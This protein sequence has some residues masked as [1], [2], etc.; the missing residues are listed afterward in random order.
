MFLALREM[1]RAV[2]RYTLLVFAIGLLVFLILFQQALQDGLITSF[3]GGVRNQTAPVL[4][5]S[6]DAQRTLQGSAISPPL[7]E[8]I[9][10]ADGIEGSAR[11]G[12]STFTVR[13]DGDDETDAAILGTDDAEIFRPTSLS[14]GR[15]PRAAGEAVGSDADFSI[16]DEVEVVPTPPGSP[17]KVTVV[18]VAADIQLSV[19]PTLFTDLETYQGAVRAVNPEATDVLP[20]ALALVPSGGTSDATLVDAVNE[21]A[22]DA[23][24]LTRADAA[25][26]SPGVA[27]VRQSFQI[28][29][30]LYGLVVPLVT[31][32]FFL[33]ITLQKS[34]SL[35]LLRAMGARG[36]TLVRS[37]LIQVLVVIALGLAVGIGLYYPLS[38]AQVGG[39]SL[40]FDPT[41]VLVWSTILLALGFISALAS[42][43]RVL[44]IDPIEATTGGGVR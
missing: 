32:L 35:T 44:Q 42:M 39:L 33:I 3:V 28:I 12:Q 15:R 36:G 37:L 13:I 14:D 1:R 24:A 40:R 23:E 27:Q 30:L 10:R 20:N 22:P 9:L 29:F 25:D 31:G 19:S 41:V 43:R 26:K 8:Q 18:G 34:G 2:V 17:V 11:V 5:Y 6:V 38:Q 4:V 21:A 7:E 16:G